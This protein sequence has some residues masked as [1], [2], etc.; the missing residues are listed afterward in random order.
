MAR[1]ET[2]G[3]L[4][5]DLGNGQWNVPR[6]REALGE[7]LFRNQSFQDFEIEHDFPYIGRRMVRLNARRISRD[8]EEHR[9]VLLAIED[10]T[11]R[12][13]EAEMRYQRLF[14][15]A[16]DGML[17]FDS[18]T[19]RLTDVNPFFLEIDRLWAQPAGGAPPE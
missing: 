16:K 13:E 7:A 10:V 11:E 19:E 17:V 1:G 6:L 3:R 5:Y 15:T 8:T 2:E 18:E 14:E 9:R 4:L 12:R